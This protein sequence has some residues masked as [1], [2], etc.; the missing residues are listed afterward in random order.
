SKSPRW[1]VA[2]KFP[3][4]ELETQVESIE[5]Q[6][7]RTGALTPV[8]NLKAIHVGGVNVARA[9]L[10]NEQELRRKDVRVGDWVLVRRAGDVIPE[11]VKVVTAR[12]TGKEIEFV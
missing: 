11:I 3:P 10:H 7:G 9:T 4:E 5:I 1:A 2:Y 6:V 8:A 12:R